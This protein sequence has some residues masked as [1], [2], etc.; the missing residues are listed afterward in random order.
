M[1]DD[2]QVLPV[3]KK[4]S[5]DAITEA[6]E[7]GI[8]IFGESRVQEV[9]QKIPLCSSRLEWHM[10]GHLQ[11]NKV[12]PAVEAFQMIHSVDSLKLL[13]VIDRVCDESGQSMPVLLQVNVSGEGSKSGFAPSEIAAVLDTAAEMRRTEIMGLMTMPPFNEDPDATRPYFAGLRELRDDLR[14]RSGLPLEQLSMGMSHDFEIAVEEGATW[15]RLGSIL[16]GER[17]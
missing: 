14:E 17:D 13:Q 7:Y 3:S 8:E 11:S 15:I 4:K 5:P 6:A 9:I 1:P 2:V 12:Q 10:I 16:F